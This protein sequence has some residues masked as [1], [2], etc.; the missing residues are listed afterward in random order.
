MNSEAKIITVE[1]VEAEIVHVFENGVL[2]ARI[3]ICGDDVGRARWCPVELFSEEDIDL[4]RRALPHFDSDTTH[5]LLADP[6]LSEGLDRQ[7]EEDRNLI[8]K[9]MWLAVSRAAYNIP[10][11]RKH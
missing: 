5:L 6:H 4:A 7:D 3:K 11:S 2:E 1:K 8:L 9:W 10:Q